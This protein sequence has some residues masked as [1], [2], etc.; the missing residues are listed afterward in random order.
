MIGFEK[1][2]KIGKG[3]DYFFGQG[4]NYIKNNEIGYSE[5][6]FFKDKIIFKA[7]SFSREF[8]LNFEI[9]ENEFLLPNTIGH[10]EPEIAFSVDLEYLKNLK[11]NLI[12]KINKI[13][14]NKIKIINGFLSYSE[15][16]LEIKNS[17]G[18]NVSLKNYGINGKIK[19]SRENFLL[20]L[21]FTS[22]L[23]LSISIEDYLE[24]IYPYLFLPLPYYEIK[25][26]RNPVLIYPFVLAF[27]FEK[28]LE[29]FKGGKISEIPEKFLIYD[30]P[31]HE[32]S[33]NFF[34]IDGEGTIK[35]EFIIGKNR[36]PLD[37]F[38]AYKIGKSS[39]GNSLRLSIYEPPE[40]GFHNL[41]LLGP[42]GNLKDI[43]Y[44]IAL[45]F[46]LSFEKFGE[47][48]ILE[49]Q[50]FLYKNGKFLNFFPSIFIKFTLEDFFKGFL[51]TKKPLIFYCSGTSFGVPFLFLKG[52]SI[53]PFI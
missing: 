24:T 29:I 17:F 27:I 25:P 39:T 30:L 33:P 13:F 21:F 2:L 37:S 4:E 52:L 16:E 18:A 41:F 47:F 51:F 12:E 44:F 45:T 10:F 7:N 50:G 8:K 23:N 32:K 9:M 22:N 5:R 3:I 38:K 31:F 28:I 26:S 36:I 35:K 14:S 43:D 15:F 49:C 19:L 6:F 40:I 11:E 1:V 34:P 48:Y 46:P 42:D 20:E 53:Y